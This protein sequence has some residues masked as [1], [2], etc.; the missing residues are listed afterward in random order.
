MYTKLRIKEIK[1]PIFYLGPIEPYANIWELLHS[2][3]IILHT[4][5]DKPGGRELIYILK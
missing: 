3:K 2:T 4:V 5:I 1:I